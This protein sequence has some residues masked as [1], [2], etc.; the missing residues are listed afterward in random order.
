M[1]TQTAIG[2]RVSSSGIIAGYLLLNNLFDTNPTA[3]DIGPIIQK[4][5]KI[6]LSICTDIGI[7]DKTPATNRR[8]CSVKAIW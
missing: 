7:N 6:S 4:S 1:H 5:D 3:N 2:I 8:V